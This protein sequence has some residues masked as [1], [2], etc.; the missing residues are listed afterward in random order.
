MRSA[1]LKGTPPNRRSQ[2][3]HQ[4]RLAS[5][6]AGTGFQHGLDRRGAL[7]DCPCY[8]LPRKIEGKVLID[9][10]KTS[11]IDF[12]ECAPTK[13][14]TYRA[15]FLYPSL[16][17]ELILLQSDRELERDLEKQLPGS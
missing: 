9:P 8:V 5:S 15:I 4:V 16:M 2:I 10:D 13:R 17:L 7:G 14:D 6:P 12:H 1:N 3:C 11:G